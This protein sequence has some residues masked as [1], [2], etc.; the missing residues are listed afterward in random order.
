MRFKF[1]YRKWLTYSCILMGM[2]H[3]AKVTI[4]VI[5]NYTL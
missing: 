5:I 1:G 3:F 4:C 2:A